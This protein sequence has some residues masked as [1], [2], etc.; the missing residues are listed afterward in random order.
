MSDENEPLL[1]KGARFNVHAMTL[2]GRDGTTHQ[3]EV[4]RHP[5]AVVLLPLI[6]SDT[7]VLIENTRLTVKETLLELPA[8][9]REV[10]EPVE[11]TAR[12]ELM[13]ETGYQAAKLQP[14]HQFYSAPGICDELMHLFLAT[15]LTE[16]EPDRESTEEIRNSVLDREEVIRRIQSGAIRDAKTLVGL[17]AWLSLPLFETDSHS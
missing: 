10:G 4:I 14:I 9:T 5:G 7:V 8:G 13:E 3:R 2:T 1:L 11:T 15:E 16:G 6:D 17:Y 12:R